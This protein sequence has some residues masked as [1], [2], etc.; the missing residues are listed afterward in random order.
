MDVVILVSLQLG[1]RGLR[2]QKPYGLYL[3]TRWDKKYFYQE[4][5]KG[6]KV[7]WSAYR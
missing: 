1:K 3:V 5:L 6:E 2:R 4:S 7:L